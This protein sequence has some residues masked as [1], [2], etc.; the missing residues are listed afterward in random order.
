MKNKPVNVL[1]C[2]DEIPASNLIG[3]YVERIPDLNLVD[4]AYSG[5]KTLEKLQKEKIDLLFLDINLPDMT[6]ISILE[7]LG[8]LPI[9]RPQVIVTTSYNEYAL[10]GFEFGVCDYLPKPFSFERFETAVSR[11]VLK[12]R[13]ARAYALETGNLTFRQKGDQ[14]ILP[15]KQIYFLASQGKTT[16]IVAKKGDYHPSMLLKDLY[17]ELPSEMFLRVH[18][19]FVVNLKFVSHIRYDAGGRYL[20]Y[21]KNDA[22]DILPVGVAFAADL[23]ERLHLKR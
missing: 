15:Y 8:N 20:A 23:K 7:E 16:R 17:A 19:Q 4:F 21:V 3:D 13:E 10:K 18:K 22:A 6:G 2:E 11:A 5:R 12:I 14:V 9:A 1:I